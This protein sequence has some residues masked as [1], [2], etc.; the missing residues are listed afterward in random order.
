V[1]RTV[2]DPLT[3]IE[4]HLRVEVEVTNGKI[5][6][7]WVAAPLFRGMEI[8]MKDRH[9]EDAF[10]VTQRI[11]GVCPISHSHASA[12]ATESALGIKIPNNARI[13]RNLIEAAQYI[14][15]HILWFYTLTALD[16]VNPINALSA[17]IGDTFALADEAGAALG[18]PVRPGDFGAVQARLKAFAENGQLSI[19]TGHYFDHPGYVLPPELDLIATTHY[20][21]ALEMQ[22]VAT[23]IIAIMSGKFPHPMTSIPGGTA[24]VPTESKLDDILF[25]FLQVKEFVDTALIPDTLIIAPYLLDA[26][27][28]GGGVGKFL[29][30]GVFEGADFDPYK[31]ALP[32][33]YV[34]AAKGLKVEEVSADDVTE[35]VGHSWFEDG[36][37]GLNPS[38]GKTEPKFSTYD[39]EGK[40][41]WAKAASCK[42][43]PAEAGPLSRML[44]GYIN[45]LPEVTSLIDL[46]LEKLGVAGKPEILVSLL[47]RIAARNLEAKV[48]ADWAVTWC[49]ELIEA[50]KSGDSSYFVTERASDGAGAGLW[51]A[52]R[53]ALGHWIDVKGGKIDNYQ[54]ITPST[55]DTSPRDDSGAR[56]PM[57]E[58]FVGVPVAD[59]ERPLEV[60]RIAHSF[61]P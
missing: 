32:R 26:A 22:G 6:D 36:T 25:R 57:E 30:W 54:I 48:I 29:S 20:L 55:W 46:T 7:A 53:G 23:Q 13:I 24:F 45:G 38:K 51:E 58:A 16:Y 8:I 47:G 40:Y 49:M 50:I 28:Y 59:A 60:L 15:S 44:V 9:P 17:D 12:M 21:Q 27:G 3:R 41:S 19:F 5:A 52:P 61:D 43:A 39:T 34:D 35:Y 1:A 56:G 33:G 18:M 37:T 2:V 14:H 10:W 4:G 11:C 31:R 42:G